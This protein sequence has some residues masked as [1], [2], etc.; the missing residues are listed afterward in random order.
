VHLPETFDIVVIGAGPAG[1]AAAAAAAREGMSVLLLE[2]HEKIGIPLQC[3]EGLS[4]STIKGWLDIKPEWVA[5]ELRGSIARG[6]DGDEFR[7]EYPNVGWVMNRKVFDPALVEIARRAGAVLKLSCRAVGID[8]DAVR[9]EETGEFKKHRFRQLIAADGIASRIGAGLGIDTR[10]SLDEI[11]VCAQYVLENIRL[12]P[13]YSTLIFGNRHAP[14]GYAWIFPK[15]ADTANVGLGI[16]PRKTGKKAIAF[17]DDWVKREFPAARIREK[18]FGG[19][20]AKVLK[21]FS[22]ENFF[23]AGDAA[24]LTDPL[25]GAG[26]ANAV[27]S[28]MIAGRNAVQRLRGRKD[29]FEAEI[30]K[31]ILDEVKFHHR[32]R[33]VYL[34]LTDD[35]HRKIFRMSKKFFR[36]RTVDDINTRELVGQALKSLPHLL[37]LLTKIL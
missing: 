31:E 24:R 20:P 35:D 23:L 18:I 36:G 27:K 32:V 29:H 6:P 4:R 26:I 10:L 13:V 30:K 7:I 21:K 5:T 11:E 25:S 33:K 17:L 16:A 9:V 34:K 3:A 22:G 28:G 37:P 15:S 19:V 2:E 12:D 8:G 1:S 14:G